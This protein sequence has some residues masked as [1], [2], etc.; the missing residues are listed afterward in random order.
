[1]KINDHDK[2]TM[3]LGAVENDIRKLSEKLEQ[4][5]GCSLHHVV[6]RL[7]RCLALAQAHRLLL[8]Y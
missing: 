4:I 8:L 3:L 2:R 5:T 1:M 6:S 7:E